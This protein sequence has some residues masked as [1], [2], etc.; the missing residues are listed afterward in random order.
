M[1]N[2]GHHLH[3]L[4]WPVIIDQPHEEHLPPTCFLMSYETHCGNFIMLFSL[5][6]IGTITFTVVLSDH[7]NL[8]HHRYHSSL[9]DP[10]AKVVQ[11][12]GVDVPKGKELTQVKV[13]RWQ[14]GLY[15]DDHDVCQ[16][17]SP[18][19]QG[20]VSSLFWQSRRLC[21]WERS[22]SP[23]VCGG[24]PQCLGRSPSTVARCCREM[25][26]RDQH[27]ASLCLLSTLPANTVAVRQRWWSCSTCP[28]STASTW[29]CTP[30]WTPPYGP[31]RPSWWRN[32]G[33]PLIK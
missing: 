23:C 7:W 24:G 21:S 30:G 20:W 32:P 18:H 27:H 13:L 26:A 29:G 22:A 9:F 33:K 16:D 5:R 31:C 19:R 15:S 12:V 28:T 2:K 17:G 11:G 6:N 14:N 3:I 25:P 8:L 1:M 4:P 10:A